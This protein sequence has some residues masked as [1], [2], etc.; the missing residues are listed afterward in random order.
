MPRWMHEMLHPMHRHRRCRVRDI[1]D[2]LHPQQRIAMAVKQHRQPNTE[3]GPID[4]LLQPEPQRADFI[5]VGMITLRWVAMSIVRLPALFTPPLGP[6]EAGPLQNVPA[7]SAD[8][9][10]PS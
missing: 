9:R 2:A 3:P 7:P 4:R 8:W 5:R 6:Q 10:A 1:E